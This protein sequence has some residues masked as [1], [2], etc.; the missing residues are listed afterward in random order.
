MSKKPKSVSMILT[1]YDDE[2]TRKWYT[3]M[4]KSEIMAEDDR[5]Y[6]GE[7]EGVGD[8]LDAMLEWGKKYRV[9]IEEV[10]GERR[11]EDDQVQDGE[12]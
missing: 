6:E 4:S 11:S 12:G 2:K 10:E 3:L 7:N 5:N 8:R 1:L 9:T